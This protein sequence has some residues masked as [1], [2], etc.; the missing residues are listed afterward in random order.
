[1]CHTHETS[2]PRLFQVKQQR[3]ALLKTKKIL[4]TQEDKNNELKKDKS[5]NRFENDN[6]RAEVQNKQESIPVGCVPTAL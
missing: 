1:M 3:T 4:L 2:V 5:K 6:N